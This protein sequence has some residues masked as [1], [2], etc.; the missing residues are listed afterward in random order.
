MKN[1]TNLTSVEGGS[2]LG[3]PDGAS[4]LAV[5]GERQPSLSPVDF[6][7]EEFLKLANKVVDGD[8]ASMAALNDLKNRWEAKFGRRGFQQSGLTPATIGICKAW[9]CLL[10]ASGDGKR[11]EGWDVRNSETV[12]ASFSA[13]NGIA[14]VAPTENDITATANRSKIA[15]AKDDIMD[16]IKGD[17]MDDI[18]GDVTPACFDD[19]ECDVRH[20]VACCNQFV[21]HANATPTGLFV[22]KIPLHAFTNKIDDDKIAQEFNNSSRKTL[23]YIAPMMQNG[24][25]VVRPTLKAVRDGSMR[26]KSTAVGYFMG[27]RPYF[28]HLKDF[29]HSIWPSL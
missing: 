28:H 27:K 4:S 14:E 12:S 5:N 13:V 23:S 1:G 19:V 7:M 11:V 20:D 15:D 21:S 29:A 10:P 8:E 9:R 25:V 18:M 6:N 24:E 17:V 26:W 22:G 16:D 2:K 3:F